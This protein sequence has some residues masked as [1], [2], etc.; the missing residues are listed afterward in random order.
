MNEDRNT[1]F[2]HHTGGEPFASMWE[3]VAVQQQE[4]REQRCLCEDAK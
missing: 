1:Y 3:A 4:A 2:S